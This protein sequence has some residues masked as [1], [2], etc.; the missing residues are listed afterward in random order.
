[1]HICVCPLFI[2]AIGSGQLWFSRLMT[3]C[4]ASRVLVCEVQLCSPAYFEGG[5]LEQ[6]INVRGIKAINQQ[7]EDTCADT[8]GSRA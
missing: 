3:S 1:M 4:V 5:V 7:R 2:E 8:R 6:R